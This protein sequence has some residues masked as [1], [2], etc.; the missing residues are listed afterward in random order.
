MIAVELISG[1]SAMFLDGTYVRMQP[2]HATHRT[3]RPFSHPCP[4]THPTLPPAPEPTSGLDSFQAQSVVSALK[5]LAGDGR[6][7]ITVIHQPRS[8]IFQVRSC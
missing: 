2:A 7:I 5:A 6:T 3:A 8:S 1:P 4:P